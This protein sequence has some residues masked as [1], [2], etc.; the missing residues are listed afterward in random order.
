MR[1]HSLPLGRAASNTMPMVARVS[2]ANFAESA[3]LAEITSGGCGFCIGLGQ[4]DTCRY[5][6]CL[7]SQPKGSGSVQALRISCTAS[8]WRSQD[9]PGAPARGGAA[10]PQGLD[11]ARAL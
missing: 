3:L 9:S 1:M 2:A 8:R 4:I 7:P 10:D 5:W 11:G 6:K